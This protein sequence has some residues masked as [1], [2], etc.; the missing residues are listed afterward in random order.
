LSKRDLRYP[1]NWNQ[2][3]KNIRER[4][5]H[6]CAFCGVQNHAIGYRDETGEFHYLTDP[7]SMAGYDVVVEEGFD[8]WKRYKVIRIILTVAHLGVPRFVDGEL[9]AGDPHDKMDCRPENLKAL[10]QKCHLDYDR[11]ENIK[12]RKTRSKNY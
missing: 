11:Q 10:C 4:D 1:S 8:C 2:I 5:G 12:S 7:E 6:R 9:V 3:S